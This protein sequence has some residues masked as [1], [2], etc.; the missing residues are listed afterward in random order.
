MSPTTAGQKPWIAYFSMEIAL[1]PHIPT[2]SG[3]LGVL[4]GDTLRA[5]ADLGLPVVGVTLVY[6][7]GYFRQRVDRGGHQFE[8]EDPWHPEERAE[9]LDRN[10]SVYIEGRRVVIRAWRYWIHGAAGHQVAVYLLDTGFPENSGWDQ[11]LTD[12]LYGGDQYY[13][14]CQEAILGI[15]G[16]KLLRRLGHSEIATFHMNE[17][18]AALLSLAL[19]EEEIGD[20]DL[21]R[22]TEADIEEVRQKCVFT[23]HTPVPAGHDQFPRELMRQILGGGRASVLEATQCCP[24]TLLNMTYLALRFSRYV[25]GVAMR[26]GEV[27]QDMFPRYPVHAITNGIHATTWTTPPFQSLYDIHLPGWRHDN[28]YL[29]YAI[30]IGLSEIRQA[31]LM[32]KHTLL[33]AVETHT[34]SRLDPLAF[35][36]GFARRAATYKRPDLVLSDP[37]RLI[38]MARDHG[39]IQLVFGGKAHPQDEDGKSLIRRICEVSAR[40][41]CEALRIVYVPNYDMEWGSLITSG[42]DL[43]LNTP[44]KPQEASGTSG[45]KA[46]LNGVPSLSVLDGWWVEGC[47]EGVTGW[48]IEDVSA[49]PGKG[50]TE[51]LYSKLASI[52]P[53]FYQSPEE[54]AGV[55]RSAIAINGSFFNTQRMVMQYVTN[56]YSAASE[57]PGDGRR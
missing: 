35:T 7:K 23:T 6:R 56:A 5:A 45:M 4:A 15:G 25:N 3:G 1:E 2:Y 14:L 10:T 55:M 22:A 16:V 42:V 34:G 26:H 8:D 47:I 21:K 50:E 54:Y 40:Y 49:S 32:A 12:H 9:L 37:E 33:E 39:P 44:Q 17:G 27:S 28:V 13:R 19:L 48:S 57:R 38:S 31:H 11:T 20:P 24:E 43:W 46:A 29:R 51:S 18:H 36:I 52:L 30:K 53:M 41:N